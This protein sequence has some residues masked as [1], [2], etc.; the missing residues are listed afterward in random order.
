LTI[1]DVLGQPDT[2][3]VADGGRERRHGL[4]DLE[5]SRSARR[6]K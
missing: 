4:D 5:K 3:R 2:T 6:W 1:F